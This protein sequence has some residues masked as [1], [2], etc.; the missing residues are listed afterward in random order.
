M[1]AFGNALAPAEFAQILP[2]G[3]VFGIGIIVFGTMSIAVLNTITA[4]IFIG[5]YNIIARWAGGFRVRF[6]VVEEKSIQ[7]IDEIIE[8]LES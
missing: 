4:I 7:Q 3:S 8:E 2:V 5:L 6:D 1:S